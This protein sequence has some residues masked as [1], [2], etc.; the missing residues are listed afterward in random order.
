M[1]QW[2]VELN[3]LPVAV[4]TPDAALN[5]I[6]NVEVIAESLPKSS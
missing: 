1:H 5:A 4:A 2:V 6:W 3:P